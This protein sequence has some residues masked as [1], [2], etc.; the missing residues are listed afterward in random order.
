LSIN[1]RFT[2]KSTRCFDFGVC[3]LQIEDS[4]PLTDKKREHSD[5]G[6]A[7]SSRTEGTAGL[8]R[9]A[10]DEGQALQTVFGEPA[11]EKPALLLHSCCGPCSTAVIERLTP[12][13]RITLYFCNSNI[14]NEAE[15][16]KRFEAQKKY[17]EQYNMSIHRAEPISLICA[18]YAPAAFLKLIKGTESSEEGGLRCRRCIRDR[19]EK[20]ATFAAMNGYE[21]FSTTLSVSRHKSYKM[22]REAG[23]ELAMRYGLTFLDEDFKKGGGEQRSVELAKAYG[24]YRQDYCGCSFSKK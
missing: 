12:R 16:R 14:D 23:K 3:N 18:P 7:D 4:V 2:A 19:L 13:F 20:T 24:L 11:A 9:E 8:F 1:H 5:S 15:F 10:G 17:V 21:Y 6:C 22:I